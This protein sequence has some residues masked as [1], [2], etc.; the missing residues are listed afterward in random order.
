MGE[1]EGWR[2]E[3]RDEKGAANVGRFEGYQVRRRVFGRKIAREQWFGRGGRGPQ[4]KG[5]LK[6]DFVRGS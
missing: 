2:K 4:G 5:G 6:S 1:R 3:K